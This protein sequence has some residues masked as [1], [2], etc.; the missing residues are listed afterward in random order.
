[1]LPKPRAIVAEAITVI[2]G[3]FLAAM[4]VGQMPILKAWIKKQ[5]EP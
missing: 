4:I 2:A 3:A 5:W 1:M